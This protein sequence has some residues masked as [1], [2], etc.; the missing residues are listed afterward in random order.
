MRFLLDTHIYLLCINDDKRLS[1]KAREL[2]LQASQVYV[3]SVSIW[4]I[5][6]KVK[7]GKLEA[8]INDVINAI[9]PTGLLELPLT[10]KHVQELYALPIHHRDPFDRILISQAISEPLRLLTADEKLIE[11]SELVDLVS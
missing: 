8:D 3:S 9:Q 6:I 4:E 10:V 5:S 11:Y 1:T 7:L 2:I